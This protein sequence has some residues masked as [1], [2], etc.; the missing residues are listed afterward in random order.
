MMEHTEKWV[1][2]KF[3]LNNRK[4]EIFTKRYFNSIPEFLYVNQ[5][6][7]LWIVFSQLNFYHTNDDNRRKF[8]YQYKYIWVTTDRMKKGNEPL[9]MLQLDSIL[10]F[11]YR[12]F[13]ENRIISKTQFFSRAIFV[14]TAKIIIMTSL[15]KKS[16]NSFYSRCVVSNENLSH[17]IE[18]NPDVTEFFLKFTSSL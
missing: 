3:Y 15:K 16:T 5:G 1:R 14:S 18:K 13:A 2:S 17:S 10:L 7:F 6:Q 8:T 4:E 12:S 11:K 9:R